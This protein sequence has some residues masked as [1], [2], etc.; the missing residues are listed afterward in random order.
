MVLRF[1][2]QQINKLP[3]QAGRLPIRSA[4]HT[5]VSR[6]ARIACP[7]R[8]ATPGIAKTYDSVHGFDYIGRLRCATQQHANKEAGPG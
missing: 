2:P 7:E 1:L 6:R 5:V 8:A 4:C 3:M